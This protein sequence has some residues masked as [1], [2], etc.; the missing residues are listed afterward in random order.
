MYIMKC[1][2]C[3]KEQE[4]KSILPIFGKDDQ[5][6]RRKYAISKISEFREIT[7]CPECEEA[8]EEW[9]ENIPAADVVPV[10]RC[11][12][13]GERADGGQDDG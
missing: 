13:W 5:Q 7:L 1:D 11:R 4:M 12:A 3:G 2:R 10:V 9:I 8:L 6:A